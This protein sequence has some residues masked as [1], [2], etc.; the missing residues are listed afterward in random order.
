GA[1]HGDRRQRRPAQRT[2]DHSGRAVVDHHQVVRARPFGVAQRGE[3]SGQAVPT[4]RRDDEG[5]GE[6]DRQP[7]GHWRSPYG[8]ATE[9][10]RATRY[11]PIASRSIGEEPKHSRASLMSST[12][13]RP[14][15]FRLVFTTTGSPVRRSKPCNIRATSGSVTGSTVCTRA[16]PSTCT[17]AGI[18]SR[19]ASATSWVNNMYGDGSGPRLKISAAR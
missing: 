7:A 18:R 11:E 4:R 12:I 1:Q 10:G 8:C 2:T 16:V 15:V 14:A 5:G 6:H 3:Q 9:P 13:G 17:T 19:Q